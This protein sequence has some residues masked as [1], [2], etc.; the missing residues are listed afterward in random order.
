ME[1]RRSKCANLTQTIK[2]TKTMPK[3]AYA[4]IVCGGKSLQEWSQLSDG[5]F[6]CHQLYRMISEGGCIPKIFIERSL[7]K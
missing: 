5:E 6:S 4:S 7:E 3:N 2:E 1:Y